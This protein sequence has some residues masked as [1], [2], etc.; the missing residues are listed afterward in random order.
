[1]LFDASDQETRQKI[2][3]IFGNYTHTECLK[4]EKQNCT[5]VHP[6]SCSGA[7]VIQSG[8]SH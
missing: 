2:H 3:T 1:M 6:E 5:I 7:P 4:Y 8:F